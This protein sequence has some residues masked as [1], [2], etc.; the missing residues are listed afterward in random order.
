MKMRKMREREAKKRT[1]STVRKTDMLD[2]KMQSK[3]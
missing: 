3:R 2:L 1:T